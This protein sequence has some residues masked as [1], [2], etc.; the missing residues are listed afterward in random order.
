MDLWIQPCAACADL[1]GQLAATNPHDEL[2]LNGAGDVKDARR[3]SG[4]FRMALTGWSKLSANFYHKRQSYIDLPKYSGT[5]QSALFLDAGTVVTLRRRS[6]EMLFDALI[7]LDATECRP[8]TA[9]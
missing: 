9:D 8:G 5:S 4:H 2:T 7:Q 6:P 1:Y 3:G